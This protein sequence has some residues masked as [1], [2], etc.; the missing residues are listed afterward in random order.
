MKETIKY[1]S[2]L[3]EYFEDLKNYINGCWIDAETGSMLDV[4]NPSTRELNARL[5][6]LL[7]SLRKKK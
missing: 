5:T 1:L 6:R 7:I 2:H 3:G 4:E